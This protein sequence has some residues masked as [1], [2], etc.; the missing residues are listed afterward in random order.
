MIF[1]KISNNSEE[2][3]EEMFPRYQQI[4]IDN[5]VNRSICDG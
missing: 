4:K 1:F 5:L 2:N 3:L